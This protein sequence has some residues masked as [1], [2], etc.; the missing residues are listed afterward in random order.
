MIA[1]RQAGKIA[2]ISVLG[3]QPEGIDGF[4]EFAL[5]KPLEA[6]YREGIDE[7]FFR[8]HA[9]QPLTIVDIRSQQPFS[10]AYI[11]VY[12]MPQV[13]VSGAMPAPE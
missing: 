1:Q 5:E 13:Q 11:P 12:A 2:R 7:S 10:C 6:G 3:A 9:N 8:W 4:S